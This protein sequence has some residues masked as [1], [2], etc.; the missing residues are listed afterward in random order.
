MT[1]STS[2]RG[3][4]SARSMVRRWP[5][6][7]IFTGEWGV[8]DWLVGDCVRSHSPHPTPHTRQILRHFLDR[9]LR[10]RQPEAQQRLFGDLLQAFERDAEVGA[11]AGADDGVDFVDDDGARGA[12]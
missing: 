6:S 8:G 7:M 2:L 11:A 4:S 9:L 12:Q 5:S 10:C 1:V 3:I